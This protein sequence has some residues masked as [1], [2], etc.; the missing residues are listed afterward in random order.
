MKVFKWA[1]FQTFPIM[2]SLTL[3]VI[4]VTFIAGKIF[5][6]FDGKVGSRI[7]LVCELS[8][9]NIRE[10]FVVDPDGKNLKKISNHKGIVVTPSFSYDGKSIIYGY[11]KDPSKIKNVDL[12]LYN[13]DTEKPELLLSVEGRTDGAIFMPGDQKVIIT[14][15]K[16]GNANLYQM[17]IKS[18][19][20]T[21]ITN[22]L[23]PDVS[24]SISKD[25]N[26]LTFVSGREDKKVS[27]YTLNPAGNEKNVNRVLF[28]GKYSAGPQIS[29]DGKEIVFASWMGNHFDLFRVNS[30][31]TGLIRLTENHGS[32]EM[33]SFSPDGKFLVFSSTKK[34]DSK[35][36]ISEIYTMSRDGKNM[37]KIV[38]NLNCMFPMWSKR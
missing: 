27:I 15:M 16:D 35:N 23:S 33:G 17:D 9:S 4:A 12:Y 34:E 24:P 32:N 18:K 30:N 19:E 11:I 38:S 31:G 6:F 5:D 26:I 22:H 2:I 8:S 20:L 37:K 21:S 14:L 10:L 29:P 36:T 1:T 13:L 3:M 28:V 7:A 25:G